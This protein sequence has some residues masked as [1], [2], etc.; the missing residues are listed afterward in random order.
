MTRFR[1]PIKILHLLESAGSEIS[2]FQRIVEATARH[3]DRKRFRVHV[4]ILGEDGPVVDQLAVA[5][6]AVKVIPWSRSL[7]ANPSGALQFWQTLRREHFDIVHQHFGGGRAVRFVTRCG[8]RAKIL[9]HFHGVAFLKPGENLRAPMSDFAI[10]NSE[11]VARCVDGGARVVYAGIEVPAFASGNAPF[12]SSRPIRV[13]GMA[14]RIVELKGFEYMI[15][16]FAKLHGDYPDARLEI[17]GEGPDRVRLER[18]SNELGLDSVVR[19][20]GWRTDLPKLMSRWDVFVQPS[21]EEGFGMAALDA[22]AAGLPV[23]AS[24]VRGLPELI[25]DGVTGILV[26]PRNPKLLASATAS[27][28]EDAEKARKFG[29]AGRDRAAE[30][31]TAKR[32]AAELES[33]Y[34]GMMERDAAR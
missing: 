14:G 32:M 18:R 22:M 27:L 21:L 7:R 1:G 8:T 26:E 12:E 23:V 2:S 19:F 9:V 24:D 29:R 33:V 4:W 13:F 34:Y 16:A 31:F 25:V 30:K 11:A 15:E 5:G 28:I 6:A 3:L 20:L 10:A 17:C